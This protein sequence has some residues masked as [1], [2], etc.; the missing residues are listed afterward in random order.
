MVAIII[1][2]EN[3]KAILSIT[4]K[5]IT[6]RLGVELDVLARVLYSSSSKWVEGASLLS[7][8]VCNF[9][10]KNTHISTVNSIIFLLYEYTYKNSFLVLWVNYDIMKSCSGVI[11]KI[12][13]GHC[14]NVWFWSNL[15]TPYTIITK[16]WVC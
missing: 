9:L 3:T 4:L 15:L 16:M 5:N 6:Q 13:R 11:S 1:I 12:L 8:A 2:M 7:E 14:R 10:K